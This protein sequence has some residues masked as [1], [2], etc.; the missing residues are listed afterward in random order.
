MPWSKGE[1]KA[2]K[3]ED[4]ISIGQLFKE[5]K[6]A[7]S[8]PVAL[9]AALY[10]VLALLGYYII[11]VSTSDYFIKEMG[12]D[13]QEFSNLESNAIWFSLG[14]AMFGGWLADKFGIKKALLTSGT[15][16]AISWIV[17]GQLSA[18]WED[19]SLLTTLMF[20]QSACY[21]VMA[22]S[23]FSLFM[24]I[25]NKKVAAT[26]FTA[27]MS[28]LNLSNVFGNKLAAPVREWLSDMPPVYLWWGVLHLA[29][30]GFVLIVIYPPKLSGERDC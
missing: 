20:F 27:Y 21:G 6:V 5:A 17:F 10:A 19:K 25:S 3:N 29:V 16:M 28:M 2:E 13:D 24:S 4:I 1:L 15:L 7:F 8:K 23:S 26:Q 14:G 9:L 30:M 11:S 22:V 12:W 18:Q